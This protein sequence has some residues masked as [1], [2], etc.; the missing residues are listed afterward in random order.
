MPTNNVHIVERGYVL[1]LLEIYWK[2]NSVNILW[3][4][5][6]QILMNQPGILLSILLHR[7]ICGKAV[8]IMEKSFTEVYFR[9]NEMG[10]YSTFWL[11]PF[12][13]K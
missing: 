13:C 7:D 3:Q 10:F 6:L 1:K 8:Q 5:D 12:D 9:N 4:W 11:I 2:M